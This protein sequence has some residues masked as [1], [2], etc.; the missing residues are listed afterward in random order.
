[1][2]DELVLDR[3]VADVF[4]FFADPHNLEAITPP[5]LRFRIVR[6]S[7]ARIELGTEIEYRLRLRG[8]PVR[9]RSRITAWEPPLRFVDEQVAGPFRF[10]RHTHAFERSGHGTL[11]R[12]DVEYAVPG[13]R[14][15]DALLV[16]PDLARIFDHR[17]RTLRALLEAPARP[18]A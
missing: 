8:V 14:L 2:H 9:W 1:M 15:V 4:A 6:A 10:W 16:A 7:T 5:W 17:A 3:P 11:A 13:G 18:S 12:D